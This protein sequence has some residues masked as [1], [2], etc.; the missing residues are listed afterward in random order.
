[1]LRGTRCRAVQ[2]LTRLRLG[3]VRVLRERAHAKRREQRSRQQYEHADEED[4]G[5]S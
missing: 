5:P 3:Q 2:A 4:W 1:M